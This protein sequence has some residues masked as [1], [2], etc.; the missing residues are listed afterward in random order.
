M[1]ESALQEA[2]VIQDRAYRLL[3]WLGEAVE[4]G[5]VAFDRAHDYATEATDSV[6]SPTESSPHQLIC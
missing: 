6:M 1:N 3:R 5:F 4:R 2:L